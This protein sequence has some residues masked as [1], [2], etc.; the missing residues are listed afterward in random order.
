MSQIMPSVDID[1]RPL[2]FGKYKGRTP[3]Q[4]AKH[5]ESYIV[6][7]F[8]NVDNPP[9]SKQ[10]AEGCEM[11]MREMESESYFGMDYWNE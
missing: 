10:L 11:D 1:D 4:I 6:W 2:R 5:D 3:N 8:N 7:M 9:C